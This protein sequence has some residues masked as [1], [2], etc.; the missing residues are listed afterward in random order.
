MSGVVSVQRATTSRPWTAATDPGVSN[1]SASGVQVG[2]SWF[3]TATGNIYHCTSAAVGAAVWQHQPRV[4]AAS[5]VVASVTG[6]TTETTLATVVV[7]GNAMGANGILEIDHL[8]S[9]NGDASNKTLTIKVGA[10][11]ILGSVL[12]SVG[13]YQGRHIVS[14]RNS[15]SSQVQF[16]NTQHL[17]STTAAGLNTEF[18]ID[19]TSNFSILFTGTLTDTADTITLDRYMI[20]LMRP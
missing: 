20:R 13:V 1:D 11:F 6:T 10:N 7:P 4:L 16:R 17:F 3:N 8:W 18:A 15:A 9:T 12:A 19:T 2:D 5:A 14:N